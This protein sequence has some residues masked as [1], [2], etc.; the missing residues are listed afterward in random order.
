MPEPSL[1]SPGATGY[2]SSRHG[3]Q[4]PVAIALGNVRQFLAA[5]V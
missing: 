3:R 1:A 5:G 2:E 4:I